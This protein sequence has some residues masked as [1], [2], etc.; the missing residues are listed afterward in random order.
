[1]DRGSRASMPT[2]RFKRMVTDVYT[3][4]TLVHNSKR[5]IRYIQV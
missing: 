1:M 2:M 5:Y 3:M 4:T